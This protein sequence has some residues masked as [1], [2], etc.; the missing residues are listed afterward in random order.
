MSAKKPEFVFFDS[1]VYINLL[2][3]QEYER[4]IE[5]FL[6]G[7]Y[8]FSLSKIVFME[9]WAGARTRLEESILKQHQKALPLIGFK[10]D[11]FIEAGQIMQKMATD[12]EIE[13]RMRRRLTWDILIAI[14]ASQN[15]ALL[16]T[17]NGADFKKIQRYV[18]F[19][20]VPATDGSLT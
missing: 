4:R 6:Q 20:F 3:S 2:R 8:L 5:P 11:G 12:H 14:S 15:N 9:L 17:E 18:D 19:K 1:N 16:V 13:P 7:A 10:E